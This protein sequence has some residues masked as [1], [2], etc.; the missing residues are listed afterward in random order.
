MNTS[1]D[2]CQSQCEAW[3]RL[4]FTDEELGGSHAD[5]SIV[6]KDLDLDGSG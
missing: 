5:L 6:G 3:R 4:T 1:H 2:L